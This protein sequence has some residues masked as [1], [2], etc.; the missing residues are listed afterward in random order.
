LSAPLL[1]GN[2]LS[3]YD[4]DRSFTFFK[5]IFHGPPDFFLLSVC[6]F[7]SSLSIYCHSAT[8][9]LASPF[10]FCSRKLKLVF[11]PIQEAYFYPIEDDLVICICHG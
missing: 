4:D 3:G 9:F 7:G 8:C 5:M 11:I 2:K 6:F 10:N 1:V